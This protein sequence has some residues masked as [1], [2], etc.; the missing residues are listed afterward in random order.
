MGVVTKFIVTYYSVRPSQLQ[1]T[2]S[3]GIGHKFLVRQHPL[4]RYG[5]EK[6]KSLGWR[7]LFRPVVS[8]IKF[9]KVTLIVTVCHPAGYT[10]HIEGQCLLIRRLVYPV[11]SLGEEQS[12]HVMFF[13]KCSIIIQLILHIYTIF[14]KIVSGQSY[15]IGIVT[16]VV[17]RFRPGID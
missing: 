4:K 13:R 10:N 11:I 15:N 3:S 6:A 14:R 1:H 17:D 2:N 7:K 12:R 8:K 16:A 5:R 9:G